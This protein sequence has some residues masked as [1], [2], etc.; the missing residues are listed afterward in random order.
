[1]ADDVEMRVALVCKD[2]DK[3]MRV[4]RHTNSFSTSYTYS[5]QIRMYTLVGIIIKG[6]IYLQEAF[7]L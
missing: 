5:P 6:G 2:H 7:K 3:D 4:G 1:M